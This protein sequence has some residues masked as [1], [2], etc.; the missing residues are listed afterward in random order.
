MYEYQKN[1]RY[2]AQIADGIKEL[3]VQELSELGADNVSS[4]YRGIYFDADK[5]T[6]YR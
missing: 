6:L 2:F 1:N 3:G 5:E 4:V